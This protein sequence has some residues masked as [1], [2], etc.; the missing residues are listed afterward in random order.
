M[1]FFE[2]LFGFSPDGG[3]GSFELLL[4]LI[5]VAGIAAVVGYRLRRARKRARRP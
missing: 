4:F 1:D 5:P 3:N 2:T